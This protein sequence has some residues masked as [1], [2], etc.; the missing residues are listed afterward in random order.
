MDE[1]N[2]RMNTSRVCE[3]SDNVALGC[4]NGIILDPTAE[5]ILKK[6]QKGEKIV[7]Y[8]PVTAVKRG[9]DDRVESGEETVEMSGGDG[10]MLE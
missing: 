5:F 6:Q 9:R 7:C 4:F 8:W 10:V 3:I 1:V 2:G